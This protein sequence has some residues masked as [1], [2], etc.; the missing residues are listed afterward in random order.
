MSNSEL[1]SHDE[2]MRMAVPLGGKL[3]DPVTQF[4]PVMVFMATDGARF[5]TGQTLPVDGGV[6]MLT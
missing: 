2:M 4:A 1:A 6:L 5:I 3:G